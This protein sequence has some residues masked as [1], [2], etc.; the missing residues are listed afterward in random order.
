MS[1]KFASNQRWSTLHGRNV[2][3]RNAGRWSSLQAAGVRCQA[4]GVRYYGILSSLQAKW[5]SQ[6]AAGDRC[7]GR[8]RS[9]PTATNNHGNDTTKPANRRAFLLP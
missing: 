6:Q 9:A 4:A 8:C 1:Q 5:S 7:N 2:K 3:V